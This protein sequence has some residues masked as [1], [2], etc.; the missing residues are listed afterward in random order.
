MRREPD[1]DAIKALVES[2]FLYADENTFFS[3][4]TFHESDRGRPPPTFTAFR[5]P[6]VT[7]CL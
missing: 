4:R 2:L 7:W 3:L 1:R 6:A 5:S